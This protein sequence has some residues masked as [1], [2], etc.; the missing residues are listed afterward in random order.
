ML[1]LT[2]ATGYVCSVTLSPPYAYLWDFDIDGDR[3]KSRHKHWLDEYVIKPILAAAKPWTV[4]LQGNTSRAG[5]E[6]KNMDLSKRR[7][8]NVA[9]YIASRLGAKS[10]TFDTS[11]LGETA[12]AAKGSADGTEIAI[13]R[14]V[15]VLAQPAIMPKPKPKPKPP[16]AQFTI[17]IPP[18]SF[19]KFSNQFSIRL[20]RGNLWV[21]ASVSEPCR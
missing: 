17:S 11:W 15:V 12:A 16:K 10:C 21:T 5:S 19:G 13:D 8:Q 7:A 9:A 3:V 14:S 6:S 2:S 1:A 20:R 4:Y 18:V